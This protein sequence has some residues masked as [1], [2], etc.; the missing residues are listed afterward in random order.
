MADEPKSDLIPKL[1]HGLLDHR[2]AG[3]WDSTQENSF[4]LLALDRYFQTYEN[5]TPNFMAR[6]WLGNQYAGDHRF[7]G[8]TTER[9]QVSIPMDWLMARPGVST[10]T[11]AKAGPGRLYYR[12]AMQYAPQNLKLKPADY[13]FTV[14]RAYRG[15]DSARDV[16]QDA[17]GVWHVK[18]GSRV[19]V[20]LTMVTDNRRYHVALVD[21]L[22]AG[23]EAMNPELLV[24]GTVPD[25][26]KSTRSTWWWGGA[27][28]EHQNL[29][30]NR[31]EAFT[32]LLWEGDYSYSY[33][34][35]A[36]TP[37]T[38]VVPPAKAEEM[39]H[40][41]TFGRSGSDVVVVE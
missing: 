12:I 28:Y 37:G 5:V 11:L 34:T 15:V 2:V 39:Y 30:D 20:E 32:S 19:R 21:P 40:P 8:R 17:D 26:D 10:L 13:G 38:F 9:S 31:A 25:D 3:H 29:R 6:V 1:V 24:T 36:T 35:R 4:V 41:E 18:A 33:V 7:A 27:W 22:P 23:L 14:Q 16:H